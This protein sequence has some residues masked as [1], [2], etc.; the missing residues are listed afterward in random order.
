M[1]IP[2]DKILLK[3]RNLSLFSL[4]DASQPILDKLSLDIERAKITALAGESGTGKTLLALCI[5]GLAR[6][7][8]GIT[9]SGSI[10]FNSNGV[11]QDILSLNEKES[12]KL[13]G[14][15]I[16]IVLQD[17]M[18]YFDPNKKIKRQ[19][20][21]IVKIHKLQ[22][23]DPHL[24]ILLQKAGLDNRVLESYP[25]QLSGG[26][27]QRLAFISAS[28]PK[29]ELIIA[30]EPTTNLDKKLTKQVLD[31]IKSFC[32][33]EGIAVLFISHDLKAVRYIADNVCIIKQGSIIENNTCNE[34]FENPKN[35]HTKKLIDSFYN[36]HPEL[37]S[38]YLSE[39]SIEVKS[40]S[41]TFTLNHEF[42]FFKKRKYLKVLGN[43][44]FPLKKA[45]VLGIIGHSGSGKS[46]LARILVQLELADNGSVKIEKNEFSLSHYRNSGLLRK[47]IQLVFQNPITS[48]NRIMKIRNLLI[49]PLKSEFH[50]PKVKNSGILKILRKQLGIKEELLDR[51]PDQISG[52]E[53][54]R[55]ALARALIN[56][57]KVLILDESFSALD[58][59]SQNEIIVMLNK[60]IIEN[61]IAIIFITHDIDFAAKFCD[62][63][64][65][66]KNGIIVES[67]S[68][69]EIINSSKNE[70]TK[71]LINADY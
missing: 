41:K 6:Y 9:A 37:R 54:Q 15:K 68:T 28:L 60:I 20:S 32:V 52:G 35:E 63:L 65:I 40:V 10:L 7:L 43:V 24:E 14:D 59:I 51:Y 23:S 50:D 2:E 64:L 26:E 4:S 19:I 25:H 16:A 69:K 34:I 61:K 67:G 13:R 29:P 18:T 11:S 22:I 70:F 1:Q 5:S 12:T 38:N 47:S 62:K 27:L 42:D 45:E 44:G 33:S 55:I 30:D 58:R 57:P 71:S 21:E 8:K 56:S 17:P 53:A 49:E 3:I 46:T 66:L 36:F 31:M 48:L 39:T